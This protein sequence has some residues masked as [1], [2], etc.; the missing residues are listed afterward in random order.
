MPPVVW[1]SVQLM[2][3]SRNIG[4]LAETSMRRFASAIADMLRVVSVFVDELRLI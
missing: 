1:L 4:G 2:H 3:L